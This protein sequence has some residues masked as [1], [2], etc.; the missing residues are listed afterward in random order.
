[1]SRFVAV[2]HAVDYAHSRG[3]IHRDLKPANVMLGEYGQTLVVDWG[4]ARLLGPESNGQTVLERPILPA[5][6]WNVAATAL[7]QVVGTP[8]FMPPEQAEGRID[9]VGLASDVFAL[10]ATLYH[11]LVGQPPYTGADVL[12][13]AR[14]GEVTPARQRKRSV[15][16]ALEAVCA[17]AMAKRPEERYGKAKELAEEVERWLADEP[18]SAY[19]EPATA[20]LRRWGRRHR[21]LVSVAAA[22]LLA[23][24]AALGVGL[25]FVNAEKDRTAR[26][27]D[28]AVAAEKVAQENLKLAREAIDE[29]FNI[30]K[31]DPVFQGPR[32]E[33]ARN[34][35]LRKTLRFYRTFR[36]HKSDD[37]ALQREEADQWV[38]VAYIE[39]VLLRTNEAREAYERARGLYQK[40][41]QA[42]PEALEH[43]Q[44]LANTH[45]NRGVLLRALGKREEALKECQ[46]ALTLDQKLVQAHPERPEYQQ[47]LANTHN[48][49]GAQLRALGKREEALKEFQQA[50]SLRHNLLQAQPDVPSYQKDLANTCYNLACLHALNAASVSRN[51]H[52]PLPE[53]EKHAEQYARAAVALLK[54]A[55]STGSFRDPAWVTQMDKDSDLDFLR[56]RDDYKQFRA[57]LKPAK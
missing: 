39:Q 55:A 34:L 24:V 19:R 14:C 6:G 57:G 44:G 8:A 52:R 26:E 7:G 56:D 12:D 2:C 1:L 18:G 29:C 48:H 54:Q 11:L 38:R 27:R 9:R 32:M 41:V 4:L 49:L 35:L 51:Q 31:T 15:P 45:N 50:R 30:A 25:R 43:Q 20:R 42:D 33:K 17:K 23:A 16:A 47:E 22:L 37:R 28:R 53:R 36:D 40:L 21:T 3:V 46:Q 10:G 5:T 13:Q